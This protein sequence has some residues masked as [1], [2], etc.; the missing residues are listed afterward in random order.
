M[1]DISDPNYK[2]TCLLVDEKVGSAFS[3]SI[4]HPLA[5]EIILKNESDPHHSH[6]SPSSWASPD[7]HDEAALV[8]M[9]WTDSCSCFLSSI[10]FAPVKLYPS[11]Y[12]LWW[13]HWTTQSSCSHCL[14]SPLCSFTH[15][16]NQTS[17]TSHPLISF[18]LWAA[19]HLP[20]ECFP[21]PPTQNIFPSQNP[22]T[23]LYCNNHCI[24]TI[25]S[26][27]L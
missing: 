15:I 17:P 12:V 27:M 19:K 16:F 13:K 5:R 26:R 8:N 7:S 24:A 23:E 10:S 11:A 2:G 18:P 22:N 21:L 20:L 14:F 6:A 4:L 1:V 25:H 9:M 3:K